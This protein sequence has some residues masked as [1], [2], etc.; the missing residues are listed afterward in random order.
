[1]VAVPARFF[2]LFKA[3]RLNHRCGK[4][5]ANGRFPVVCAGFLGYEASS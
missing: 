5:T 3:I 4:T 2:P 1:M